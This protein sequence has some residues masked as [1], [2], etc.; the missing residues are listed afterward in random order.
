MIWA[1]GVPWG[2]SVNFWVFFGSIGV[3]FIRVPVDII[4]LRA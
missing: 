2:Q 3:V 4:P 1:D